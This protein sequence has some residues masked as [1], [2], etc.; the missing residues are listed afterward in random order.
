[1]ETVLPQDTITGEEEVKL[2]TR[3]KPVEKNVELI[4]FR[5]SLSAFDKYFYY[6]NLKR[7]KT[8]RTKQDYI[9]KRSHH[10]LQAVHSKQ[11]SYTL[12]GK[13]KIVAR[14]NRTL[15]ARYV[16][17]IS[18][19][20][21]RT[22]S[23]IDLIE[24]SFYKDPGLTARIHSN[25]ISYTEAF[26]GSGE[27]AVI[28]LVSRVMDSPEKS[29]ILLDEPEVSIHPGAQERLVN[30]LAHQCILK[31]HQVV[32]TTHSPAMIRSLPSDA[33]KILGL[34]NNGDVMLAAQSATHD[35]A[36]LEIGEELSSKWT[37]IV[38]DQ[39][40]KELLMR[41][42]R[43]H[44]P[45]LIKAIDIR[46]YPGGAAT[47]F[48]E[49]INIFASENRSRVFCILDGDQFKEQWPNDDEIDILTSQ[50]CQERIKLLTNTDIKFSTDGGSTRDEQLSIKRKNFLKWNNK[51]TFFLQCDTP[52]KLIVDTL[53][54]EYFNNSSFEDPK[55]FLAREAKLS[56][57]LLNDEEEPSSNEIF[58]FQR[59][60]L[61]SITDCPEFK[62]IAEQI[63]SKLSLP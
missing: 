58:V 30:F 57:G 10:L 34:N 41:S 56:L 21:G 37:I 36:F 46:Y 19:I 24:H 31:H 54:T 25:Q 45:R 42:L 60:K 39:L 20:L 11:P 13:E 27:F 6:G 32:F 43:I 23:K 47:L 62:E 22:Y 52:E 26:A 3:W 35:E 15:P 40:A 33:V 59:Q 18:K 29:L 38:E 4:D 9:R 17:N 14:H 63:A 61:A 49:Y 7:T 48:K 2:K 55:L 8:V 44:Q 16:E 50:Q 12:Y 51:N 53:Y 5:H 1:M 28:N